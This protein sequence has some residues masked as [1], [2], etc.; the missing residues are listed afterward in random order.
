M[1]TDET[2]DRIL[3]LLAD[4]RVRQV[5]VEELSAVCSQKPPDMTIEVFGHEVARL[6][7]LSLHE[8]LR[9][10]CDQQLGRERAVRATDRTTAP[11]H[12]I[13]FEF[14]LNGLMLGMEHDLLVGNLQMIR[15]LG[16][17]IAQRDAGTEE[18]NARVTLYALRLGESA[19]LD[20]EQLQAL[21]KGSFVHD[22]GKIGIRDDILLKEDKLSGDEL[23]EMRSHVFR[24]CR[25]IRGVRWLADASDIVRHHHERFDGDGYPD[26]LAGEAIPRTARIFAIADVFD[27]LTTERP[28]KPAL[29][30]ERAIKQ[31]IAERGRHFDPDLMDRFVAIS[32]DLYQCVFR[33]SLSELD[34]MVVGAVTHVFG[35]NPTSDYVATDEFRRRFAGS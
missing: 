4:S 31:M 2:R 6:I 14:V 19:G 23:A 13:D 32:H 8:Q 22:I 25:I 21:L 1:L 20:T 26:G 27:A 18:H 35:V 10:E 29:S 11:E 9:D 12:P 17:A 16:G 33:L 30:C 34:G 28:Y 15:A 3:S 5:I 24:G 7:L